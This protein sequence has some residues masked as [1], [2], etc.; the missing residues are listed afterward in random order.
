MTSEESSLSWGSAGSGRPRGISPT[1]DTRWTVSAPSAITAAVGIANAIS[2]EYAPSLVLARA[3][4]ITMAD[5][6]AT[7]EADVDAPE[8]EQQVPGLGQ[9]EVPG[10]VRAHQVRQLAQDDVHARP[11]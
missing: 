6:P 1:S 10:D 3:T 7:R 2:D 9:G 4:R 8:V 11:R 5:T